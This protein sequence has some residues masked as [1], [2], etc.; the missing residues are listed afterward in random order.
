[1]KAE[2]EHWG[3]LLLALMAAIVLTLVGG[4]LIWRY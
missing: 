3:C 4:F 1:M 2:V